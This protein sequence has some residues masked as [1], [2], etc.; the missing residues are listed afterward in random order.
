MAT[1]FGAF[2]ADWQDPRTGQKEKETP[3]R[4]ARLPTTKELAQDLGWTVEYLNLLLQ[5]KRDR[6]SIEQPITETGELEFG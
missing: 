1:R 6:R 4:L 5:V 3:Q 2:L